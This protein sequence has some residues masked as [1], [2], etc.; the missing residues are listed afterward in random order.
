MVYQFVLMSN[1]LANISRGFPI[2]SDNSS[3]G[4]PL[5]NGER[6]FTIFSQIFQ[7][8]WQSLKIVPFAED[9]VNI[10]WE[11]ALELLPHGIEYTIEL[12][13]VGTTD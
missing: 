11:T 12:M 6:I 13:T 1:P 4:Y 3:I 10:L 2:S 9:G 7:R 5:A 8:H